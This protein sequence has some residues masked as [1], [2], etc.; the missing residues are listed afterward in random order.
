MNVRY[1]RTA[2]AE[3]ESVFAYIAKD[4][5]AA[6]AEVIRAVD[7]TIARLSEFPLSA[8]ATDIPNVRV[9][10]AYPHP[11]LIFYSVDN[12]TLIVR[13]I[14]HAARRRPDSDTQQA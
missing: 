13:N 7:K 2:L 5:P 14:R 8:V 3:I 11:Y 9:A 12:E 4:N 10:P 1:T 6:G